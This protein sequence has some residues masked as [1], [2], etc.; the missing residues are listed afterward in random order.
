MVE[1]PRRAQRIAEIVG[2]HQQHI[3]TGDSGDGV[4]VLDSAYRLDHAHDERRLIEQ[5]HH[6]RR[7]PSSEKGVR[8]VGEQ[9]PIS[10]GRKSS[11]LHDGLG[12]G[13]SFEMRHDDALGARLQRSAD[14]GLVLAGDANERRHAE[15]NGSNADLAHGLQR[16]AAMFEVDVQAIEA[17]ALGDRRSLD[18]AQDTEDHA[19]GK[20]AGPHLVFH[21]I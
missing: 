10:H 16:E 13:A 4:G 7:R 15:R 2:A 17:C 6:L 11:R 1:L 14:E 20:P 8:V 21:Q 3:E 19:D 5:L 12:F 18:A 9:G